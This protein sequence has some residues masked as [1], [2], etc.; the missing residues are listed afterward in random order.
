MMKDQRPK[1]CMFL[2]NNFAFDSRVERESSTLAAAG[3]D[4]TVLA[5]LY[6]DLPAY[7]ERNGVTIKRLGVGWEQLKDIHIPLVVKILAAPLRLIWFITRWSCRQL[8]TLLGLLYGLIQQSISQLR[9]FSLD[10]LRLGWNVSYSL[11]GEKVPGGLLSK[12]AYSIRRA[13]WRA[14]RLMTRS[15]RNLKRS[16]RNLMRAVRRKVRK[17]YRDARKMTKAGI[18]YLAKRV[19]L[20]WLARAGVAEQAD[21]YHANDMNVLFAAYLAARLAGARLVYDSHELWVERNVRRG[22]SAREKSSI[23]RIEGFLIRRVDAAI[24]VCH[25]IAVELS[26]MYKVPEPYVV[27]NCPTY[28]DSE[29]VRNRSNGHIPRHPNRRVLLYVGRISFNRGLEPLIEAVAQLSDVDLVLMG[30]GN[31]DY[32]EWLSEYASDLGATKLVRI[33]DPVPPHEVVP[34]ASQADAGTV[35]FQNTCLSYYYTLPTKLFECMHAGL[36]VI[37]SD[38]PEMAHIVRDYDIGIACDPADP[39]AIADAVRQ[40]FADPAHYE[41]MRQNTRAAAQVFNW[42]N[43]GAKLVNIYQGLSADKGEST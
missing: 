40:L 3:F 25:S 17:T 12:I 32:L 18:R 20:V 9:R 4:V 14:T 23:K 21:I 1:V 6:G 33:V 5:L 11:V 16:I 42:E 29:G 37:V 30:D 7:E 8:S 31:P 43:E 13:L 41:Q 15:I 28:I 10:L 27:M 34:T 39:T 22:L 2:L 24:T 26:N 19:T 36:P 35:L 38:F